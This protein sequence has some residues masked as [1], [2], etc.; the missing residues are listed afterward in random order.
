[1]SLAAFDAEAIGQLVILILLGAGSLVKKF[2]EARQV[3]E[4]AKGN[5][6][7]KRRVKERSRSDIFD[8]L[9]EIEEQ[10]G[11]QPQDPWGRG[12]EGEARAEAPAALQLEELVGEPVLVEEAYDPGAPTREASIEGPSLEGA[13]LEGASFD[14][15]TVSSEPWRP[16]ERIRASV[17]EDIERSVAK[18][19][20]EHVA[21][22][23]SGGVRGEAS[24]VKAQAK[25]QS[26]RGAHRGWR[27]AVIAAELLGQPVAL[28]GPATQPAGL[29]NE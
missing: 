12:S 14:Q 16:E 18:D 15:G 5:E 4:D 7:I 20:T 27:D 8:R 3:V 22:D 19:I 26:K 11:S 29:R 21:A 6:E 25:L 24:A 13:S 2:F 1:M 9:A 10:M 28:K 17:F 23:M